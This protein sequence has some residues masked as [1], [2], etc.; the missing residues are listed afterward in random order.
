MT[1]NKTRLV[2][3]RI[4][5]SK[6]GL[7]FLGLEL[8]RIRDKGPHYKLNESMLASAIIELFC[9]KYLKKERENLEDKFFDKKTFLKML[10]EKSTS[11]DDLSKSLN[12]F[13]HKAN[14]KKPK[15]SKTKGVTNE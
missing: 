12:E 3:K 11:E 8:K 1:K 7:E 2:V 9:T 14:V 5:L 15:Q 10:I 6:M 4:A 13:F